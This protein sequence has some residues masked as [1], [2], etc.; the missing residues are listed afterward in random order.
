MPQPYNR[1]RPLPWIKSIDQISTGRIWAYKSYTA[2]KPI[3]H[4]RYKCVGRWVW[5]RENAGHKRDTV[6]ADRTATRSMIG[7]WHDNVVCLSIRLSASDVVQYGDQ[8]HRLEGVESCIVVLLA[9]NFLFTSSHNA[10][11]GCMIQPQHTAVAKKA[12]RTVYNV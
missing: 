1:S 11:V 3:K 6:L 10:A 2:I 9:R 12:D 4:I 5:R 7:S 8:G